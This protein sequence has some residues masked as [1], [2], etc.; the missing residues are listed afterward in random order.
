[1][2][3]G[4]GVLTFPYPSP[5]LERREIVKE[6]CSKCLYYDAFENHLQGFCELGREYVIWNDVCLSWE[7]TGDYIVGDEEDAEFRKV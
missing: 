3:A 5:A 6:Y 7:D 2:V 1:M 4:V